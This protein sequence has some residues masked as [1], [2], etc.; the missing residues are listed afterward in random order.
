MPLRVRVCDLA[1]LPGGPDAGDIGDIG[2]GAL[3]G[4][5]VPGVTWPIMVARVCGQLVAFAGVCP[6]ADVSLADYGSLAG[7]ELT[8]RV[9]GYRF[10]LHTGRCAHA[11]KLQLRRYRVT[12]I[13]TAVWVDLL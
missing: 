7:R 9:H 4:F 13:D 11:P 1:D 2:D 6:H 5:D 12:I 8:C 10:D 3:R